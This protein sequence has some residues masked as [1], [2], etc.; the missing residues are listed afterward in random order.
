MQNQFNY[1]YIIN[2]VNAATGSIHH[3]NK[4]FF[5]S[6]SQTRAR[7]NDENYTIINSAPLGN[8]TLSQSSTSPLY[9]NQQLSHCIGKNL[10][11]VVLFN[12]DK[13]D[14]NHLYN[15]SVTTIYKF[16]LGDIAVAHSPQLQRFDGFYALPYNLIEIAP[17]MYGTGIYLKK[18][19]FVAIATGKSGFVKMILV[20]FS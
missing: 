13:P 6:F 12:S 5:L 4:V 2:Y 15:S 14:K 1:Q 9:D 19:G 10:S 16:E 8:A 17:I 3:P 20:Y 18:T 7:P 11:N